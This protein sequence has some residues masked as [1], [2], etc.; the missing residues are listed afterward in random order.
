VSGGVTINNSGTIAGGNGA[1]GLGGN[2]GVGG[3]GGIGGAGGLGTQGGSGAGGIAIMGAGLTINNNGTIVG[4]LSGDGVTRADAI[5]F[6]G[7]TN[8]LSGTGT[9]GSF[10]MTS[11]GTFAPGNGT[12][13]SSMTVAGSLAFASGAIYALSLNPATSSFA[14]VNGS[15]TLGGASVHAVF[16]SGSYA[17]KQYTILTASGGLSGTFAS[18]VATNLPGFAATLSYDAH[19]VFL[20]LVASLGGGS[21]GLNGNSRMSRTASTRPSMQEEACRQP[22]RTCSGFRVARLP[23][24]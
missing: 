2:G 13:G 23:T 12:P 24:R 18:G 7:G 20:N 21:G 10:T 11:G 19:D 5:V 1:A 15:A 16:A 4:G 17:A 8:F 9:V 22:L 6:T 3:N 14:S